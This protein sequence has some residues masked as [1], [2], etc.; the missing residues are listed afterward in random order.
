MI[1]RR[2]T[3]LEV[4][5]DDTKEIDDLFTKLSSQATTTVTSTSGVPTSGQQTSAAL[6]TTSKSI[7]FLL[8]QQLAE[9]LT[10]NNNQSTTS[11]NTSSLNT[12]AA[13]QLQATEVTAAPQALPSIT[14]NTSLTTQE[15][16]E[17]IGF[18]PQP[19]N[20]HNR[21]NLSQDPT[22]QLR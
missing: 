1:R 2:L 4:N 3:R 13:S 14:A 16:Q 20:P 11:N 21:F 18:N 17:R 7:S 6:P 15:I 5:L 9:A 10:N 8:R 12:T 22:Q 19:Y